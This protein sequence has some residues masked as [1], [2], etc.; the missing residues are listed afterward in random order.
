MVLAI[1]LG[2]GAL[3]SSPL[4]ASLRTAL[5]SQTLHAIHVRG[6]SRL[7]PT[8]VAALAGLE[9]GS[10]AFSP[11]ARKIAARVVEDPHVDSARAVWLQS[12]S[13]V[14]EIVER[15]PAEVVH[16]N[17]GSRWLMDATGVVY[18]R[19]SSED[20]EALTHLHTRR[21]LGV[22]Q[23][24]A[25]LARALALRQNAVEHG[26]P[27]RLEIHIS[28]RSDPE[29][30]SL[31]LPGLEGRFV[32][33]HGDRQ[34]MNARLEKLSLLLAAELPEVRRASVIDLRFEDQVVLKEPGPKGQAKAAS[35]RGH[36]MASRETPTG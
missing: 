36:A 20:L 25:S 23:T 11:G 26:L 3:L 27:Q 4:G 34:M 28:E 8:A 6:A 14:I 18:G 13:L 15:Q 19:A 29:G 2:A 17:D 22:G 16:A 7:S 5:L 1:S 35:A 30:F 12:G 24:D 9:P 21:A 10:P 31:E 32:L 33:G